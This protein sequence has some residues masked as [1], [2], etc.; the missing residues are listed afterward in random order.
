MNIYKK[1]SSFLKCYKRF[2]FLL[3]IKNL[4]GLVITNQILCELNY[5]YLETLYLS[6][7]LLH[8]SKMIKQYG[9]YYND[10]DICMA[11]NK[12]KH[13]LQNHYINRKSYDELNKK[14]FKELSPTSLK[15]INSYK[16]LLNNLLFWCTAAS[17]NAVN[18]INDDFASKWIFCE[19]K[20]DF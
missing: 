4:G 20:K 6:L 16:I 14:L 7:P 15:N 11:S 13:I 8:N 2:P 5:L 3:S 17:G 12:I 10:F 1:R 19:R 18:K 9:Y